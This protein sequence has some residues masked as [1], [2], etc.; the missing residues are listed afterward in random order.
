MTRRI[1]KINIKLKF[2]RIIRLEDCFVMFLYNYT[3]TMD[4]HHGILS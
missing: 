4:G 2:L 3:L 1:L